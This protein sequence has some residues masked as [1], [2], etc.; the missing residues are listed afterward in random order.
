MEKFLS[1]IISSLKVEWFDAGNDFECECSSQIERQFQKHK[2]IK[3]IEMLRSITV[4]IH[5]KQ[6]NYIMTN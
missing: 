5:K 6:T 1:Q 3:K 2:S 4:W